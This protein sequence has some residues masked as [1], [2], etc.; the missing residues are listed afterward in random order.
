VVAAGIHEDDTTD[1][2][3]LVSQLLFLAALAMIGLGIWQDHTLPTAK[4]LLPAL[5][6]TPNA[7]PVQRSLGSKPARQQVTVA[8]IDYVIDPK[9]EYDITGL[10]VSRHDTSVWWNYLHEQNKDKLNVADLCLT[11]GKNLSTGVYR[12]LIYRSGQFTCEIGAKT[13]AT[14]DRTTLNQLSNNHVLASDPILAKKLRSIRPGDQIR[15]TGVLA[16]YGRTGPGGFMRA[17]SVTR[18]DHGNGAC[19][20]LLVTEVQILRHRDHTW[21]WLRNAG[22]M[23]LLIACMLWFISPIQEN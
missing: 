8:G 23:L 14:M 13:Q 18:D 20:M 6:D 17:T 19:E 3:R 1:M 2:S 16:D 21:R 11:W 7:A 10:V 22:F 12:E 4:H 9:F 5:R 15:M